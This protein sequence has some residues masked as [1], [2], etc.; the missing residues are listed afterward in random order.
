MTTGENTQTSPPYTVM[1]VVQ[2]AKLIFLNISI[3]LQGKLI[4]FRA[5][6]AG[7]QVDFLDGHW[8]NYLCV[9]HI[10]KVARF[11]LTGVQDKK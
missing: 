8:M 7:A 9:I 10:P 2:V 1:V 3:F 5:G 4:L 11:S 6:Y